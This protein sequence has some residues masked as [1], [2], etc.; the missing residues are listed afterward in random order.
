MEIRALTEED[1]AAYWALRYDALQ[2]EPFA[3]GS[4]AEEHAATTVEQAAAR[5]RQ[6][7]RPSFT[8]GAFECG[9]LVGI[10]TFVKETGLKERHKGHIYGVFVK[11]AWR[12]RG[13]GKALIMAL[14]NRAKEDGSLEQILL[15]VATC[16][17]AAKRLYRQF[18]FESFGTELRALKVGT[19]YVDEDHMLL[20]VR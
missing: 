5:I 9:E 14:L 7:P 1:A 17:E 3:F 6:T 20:R 13:V 10:A 15:A 4:A 16:Q 12:N 11:Q 19:E 8:W 2:T 18:G